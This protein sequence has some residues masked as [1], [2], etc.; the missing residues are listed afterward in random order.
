[1]SMENVPKKHHSHAAHMKWRITALIACVALVGLSAGLLLFAQTPGTTDDTE[2]ES[3]DT[4]VI[5]WSAEADDI[6][7]ITIALRDEE[8]WTAEQT[9]PGVLTLGGED[10]YTVDDTSATTLLD[11]LKSVTAE[12]LSDDWDGSDEE[13]ETM[14]LTDPENVVRVEMKDGTAYTLMIGNTPQYDTTWQYAQLEGDSRLLSVSRG[15][16]EELYVTRSSLHTVTQPTIHADRVDEIT[17][18]DAQGNI[19]MQWVLDGEITDTDAEDR[20]R[21]TVPVTYPAD[22]DSLITLRKSA[23]ALRL[24]EYLCD[25]TAETLARYGFDEP[26]MV[27]QLHQA[28]GTIGTVGTSGSYETTDW[29]ASTLLFTIGAQESDLIDYVLFEGGIYRCS[30]LLFRSFLNAEAMETLTRYPLL[31]ALGNLTSLTIRENGEEILYVIT[32]VEQ[33]DENNELTVDEDGN[34][35]YDITLTKNGEEADYDA[36]SAAYSQLMMVTVSGKLPEGWTSDDEPHTEYVFQDS[37]GTNHTVALAN[38]D[39]M[40]DAV[41]VDGNAVF[42]LI[43]GGFSL[44]I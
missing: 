30:D 4:S 33:V 14:G 31:T 35:V 16:A 38:Y 19:T 13:K 44:G 40:H 28:A 2:Q 15:V 27:I 23:A 18:M 36:F 3:T 34:Q 11:A 17:L 37:D 9:T 39:A 25:T 21:M 8:A 22:A 26:R 32:R 41:Y 24:G 1:M 43:Q 29:E 42:Y 12:V 20:W 10:A 5:L 6:S 7:S